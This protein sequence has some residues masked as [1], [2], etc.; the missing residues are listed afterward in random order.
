MGKVVTL[1]EIMLRLSTSVVERIPL[2]EN[3]QA[4]YGGGEANVAISLANYGHEVYFASVLPQNGLGQA[5]LKHLKRF[6]VQ[7]DYVSFSGK[8][9][10]TYYMEAGSGNKAPSV[11]YDREGSSFATLK[12]FPFS[13]ATLLKDVEILHL[14]GITPAL[15][16]HWQ[17]LILELVRF[18][19]NSGVKVSFD[20]NYRG[21]LWSQQEAGDFLQKVLPFVDYCSAGNLDALYLLKIPPFPGEKGTSVERVY[22]YEKMQEKFPNIE[23]FYATKRKVHSA[24]DHELTGTLFAKGTYVESTTYR[25]TPIVD[26]VGGGDAF[27]GG[28]LHGLLEKMS[29]QEIVEFATAAAT[30]KHSI[31]GDCNQFSKE[32]VESFLQTGSGKIVR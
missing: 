14:S 27:S 21:L 26:R 20:V 9:L 29:P 10:G 12:A 8:R 11:I 13:L 5:V 23:V 18:A 31:A 19:K 4:H 24:S 15:A 2:A 30:L 7:T 25:I 3:F 1:G 28:I 16:P 17:D 22:Y 6:N 32:E